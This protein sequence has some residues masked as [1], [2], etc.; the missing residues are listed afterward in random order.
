MKFSLSRLIFH[1]CANFIFLFIV[2]LS[3]HSARAQSSFPVGTPPIRS[4]IDSNGVDLVTGSLNIIQND[5]SIGSRDVGL[6]FISQQVNKGW[7]NPY[8]GVISVLFEKTT[9]SVN[10][11]SETFSLRR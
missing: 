8:F 1:C 3:A 6:S 9:V 5:L 11:R 2:I 7:I 4:N 10:G